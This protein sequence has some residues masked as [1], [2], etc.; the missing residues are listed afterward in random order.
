LGSVAATALFTVPMKLKRLS[1]RDLRMNEQ[2]AMVAASALNQPVEAATRCEQASTK[3]IQMYPSSGGEVWS[4]RVPNGAGL[5]KSFVVAVTR[6]HVI[7]LEDKQHRGELVPGRVLKSWERAGFRAYV[8]N[9]AMGV[10]SGAPD[11]RQVLMLWVPID[12]D[13]SRVAQAIAQQ[14]MAAGQRVPGQPHTFFVAKD[15][16][17]Q[18]VIAALGAEAIGAPAAGPK[19]SIGGNANI[20][21]SPGANITV[22]GK[23]LQDMLAQQQTPPPAAPQPFSPPR[24]STAQRLQELETLRATGAISEAEYAH[25]REQIISDL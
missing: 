23:R 12:S 2:A 1:D 8:G 9:A 19:I 3:A 6:D 11:D 22:G 25:K 5:P 15:A 10:A 17:S 18:R 24:P 20:R 7:A 21:I 14:R 4:K 16:A 13:S